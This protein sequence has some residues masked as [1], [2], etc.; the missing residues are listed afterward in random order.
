MEGE[1][2]SRVIEVLSRMVEAHPLLKREIDVRAGLSIG[3]LSRALN[4]GAMSLPSLDLVLAAMRVSPK[5]FFN[6]VTGL[7]PAEFLGTSR[8]DPGVSVALR[9]AFLGETA[10]CCSTEPQRLQLLLEVLP[11]PALAQHFREEECWRTLQA[12]EVACEHLAIVRFRDPGAS[13][14]LARALVEGAGGAGGNCQAAQRAVISLVTAYRLGGW[15]ESAIRASQSMVNPACGNDASGRYQAAGQLLVCQ[16]KYAEAQRHFEEAL[17]MADA[18]EVA[19]Y[20]AELSLARCSILLRTMD[21]R[22]LSRYLQLLDGAG[23]KLRLGMHQHAAD[24]LL[25][26]QRFS[27]A[28]THLTLAR[29]LLPRERAPYLEAWL[30]RTEATASWKV[31]DLEEAEARMAAAVE[32]FATI[33]PFDMALASVD[34]AETK[35]ALGKFG[36]VQTVVQDTRKLLMNQETN[37]ICEAALIEFA[38]LD[39]LTTKAVLLE[40]IRTKLAGARRLGRHP[41]SRLLSG[42]RLSR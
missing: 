38:R 11:E 33:N 14:K 6:R 8:G 27:D 7:D 4:T 15:L 37:S 12:V 25:Q 10:S 20:E 36:E 23:W 2:L 31:G 30:L 42:N 41:R 39:W 16:G 28:A 26:K 3:Y 22:Q 1:L 34:L 17:R 32:L 18:R 21:D 35:I 13:A 19:Y 9:A 24:W 40:D 5:E 29:S